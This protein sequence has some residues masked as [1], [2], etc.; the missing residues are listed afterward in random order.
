MKKI[1]IVDDEQDICDFIEMMLPDHETTKIINPTE[2]LSLDL[3]Q[4]DIVI[5]DANMPEM[6]GETLIKQIK[7][8]NQN[9]KSIILSG[10][11]V[12]DTIADMSLVKP[13]GITELSETVKN[14]D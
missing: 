4:Y 7:E 6:N 8:K 1:L 3:S 2:A 9:I 11:F 10:V 13:D 12:K 14:L 5:T